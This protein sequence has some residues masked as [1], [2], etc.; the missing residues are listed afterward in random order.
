M[1]RPR[2]PPPSSSVYTN[3]DVS[4]EPPSTL[5]PPPPMERANPGITV[6]DCNLFFQ[7][8]RHSNHSITSFR[9]N[10]RHLE[11]NHHL[12]SRRKDSRSSKITSTSSR[13]GQVCKSLHGQGT[14]F[15]SIRLRKSELQ[16]LFLP[17]SA[18]GNIKLYRVANDCIRHQR[19]RTFRRHLRTPRCDEYH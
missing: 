4:F 2:S 1:L 17:I 14:Y 3:T 19:K 11:V 9:L 13:C 8:H 16:I 10:P 6:A 12:L 15:S 5:P 18:A 7:P